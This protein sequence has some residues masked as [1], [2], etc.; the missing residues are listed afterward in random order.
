MLSGSFE[1]AWE[2]STLIEQNS[3]HDP[4]RFWNG[5]SW[6]G[7]RVMIR[8]LHGL[9]DT[10]QFIRYAPLIRSVSRELTVQVHPQ[11]VTLI[12][13]V[14]A[15]D[16]VITWDGGCD[17]DDRDYWDIQMEVTELPRAFKARVDS[18]PAD[19]PYIFIPKE[20]INWSR[21]LL[22]DRSGLHIGLV[23][24]AGAWNPGRSLPFESLEPLLGKSEHTF[25]NLQKDSDLCTRTSNWP[26]REL[27]A[28]ARDIRDTAAL[29]LQ[30]DL[31]ITVDTMSAHLAGALGRPVWILLPYEADWRWMLNRS[32]TPWYPTARLFRQ[33]RP[34]D[35]GSALRKLLNAI[36][37]PTILPS[38]SVPHK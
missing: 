11:L 23:W 37:T 28:H 35:W 5:Q 34:G 24:E 16:R 8:C 10:I 13:G 33:E 25:Y 30:L 19:V 31:V 22:E 6:A 15:I 26:L 21:S 38:S 12:E 4:H 29:M 9:G 14:P 27:E 1:R 18:V 7:K 20:R 36:T 2:E 3:N 17:Q 32:D